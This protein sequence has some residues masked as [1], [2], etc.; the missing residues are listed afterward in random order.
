MIAV[1]MW[2]YPGIGWKE[3]HDYF[4][5]ISVPLTNQIGHKVADGK[6]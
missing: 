1:L 6:R 2:K 5:I 4:K 3:S